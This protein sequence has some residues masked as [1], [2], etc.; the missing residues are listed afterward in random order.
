VHSVFYL[1]FLISLKGATCHG[2]DITYSF[3]CVWLA[4]PTVYA[5]C[6]YMVWRRGYYIT[7]I[8]SVE[9]SPVHLGR[10]GLCREFEFFQELRWRD[11][12]T[13]SDR[14]PRSRDRSDHRRECSSPGVYGT[15]GIRDCF[16]DE[17]SYDF[18]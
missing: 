1:L 9:S 12:G 11:P 5:A 13:Q 18:C 2:S 17:R 3:S 7:V 10:H 14:V 15:R 6:P 8:I 16:R 4:W